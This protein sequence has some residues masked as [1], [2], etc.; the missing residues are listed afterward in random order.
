[1]GRRRIRLTGFRLMRI[2][3]IADTHIPSMAKELPP[4]VAKAFAGVDLIFHAGDLHVLSVLDDLE[5]TAPVIAVRGNGDCWIPQDPRLKDTYLLGV[6]G[7]S[8]GL[9]H[10]LEYPE[11]RSWSIEQSMERD[12]K[13][14]V[15]VIVFGD[16]H[17]A[18]VEEYKGILLINPGSPTLPNGIMRLGTVAILEVAQGKAQAAILQLG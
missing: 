18:M 7:V 17:V 2:G 4:Q 10:A 15:D 9:T 1:M 3:L 6:E 12:F 11:S 16:T 8:I 5:Q 14:A 13:E